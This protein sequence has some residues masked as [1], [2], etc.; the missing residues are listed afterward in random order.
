[1]KFSY[2]GKTHG[3]TFFHNFDRA[4]GLF[5]LE[6]LQLLKGNDML[7]N[8]TAPLKNAVE[9]SNSGAINYIW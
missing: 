7:N 9:V 1:M 8:N 4:F 2:I 6:L 5:D 3:K